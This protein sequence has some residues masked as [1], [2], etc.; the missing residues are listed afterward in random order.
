MAYRNPYLY[1]KD[2]SVKPEYDYIKEIYITPIY[3][4][5]VSYNSRIN[6]LETYDNRL[7]ILPSS[8]NNLDI[9]FN[10]KFLLD[11]KN[12]G[13]LLKTIETAGGNRY[14]KFNIENYFYKSIIGLIDSYSI[15][16]TSNQ[17]NTVDIVIAC[18]IK[19]PEFNWK[20]SSLYDLTKMRSLTGCSY[21]EN[22]STS[23]TY[24]KYDFVYND[25]GD[26]NHN[27]NNFW[28]AKNDIITSENFSTN[29]FSREFIFE[30]KIPFEL[31]NN[32]DIYKFSAKN[33]FL[34]NIRSKY[35]SNSLKEQTLTFDNIDD[36]QCLSL[37]FFLEKKCGYKRFLYDF[38]IFLK[39]NKIFICPRWEHVMNYY[40]SNKLSLTLVED[41]S[42]L[43]KKIYPNEINS[44]FTIND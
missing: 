10:F 15:S 36:H 35:N 4:S 23:K 16:K 22:H 28:F 8:A 1:N 17:S 9:K 27:V 7:K 5:S 31:K 44:Q 18:N 34:Q 29:L 14:L 33:S 37:L 3:G 6:I 21:G 38:P 13:D 39:K 26:K 30:T 24:K 40:N 42:A 20:G 25:V 41:P 32:L 2:Q 12:T 43:V 11:D 19:A